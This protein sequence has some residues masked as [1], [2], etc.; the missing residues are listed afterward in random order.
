MFTGGGPDEQYLAFSI[1]DVALVTLPARDDPIFA[2]LEYKAKTRPRTIASKQGLSDQLG[3][4]QT[5]AMNCE[6]DDFWLKSLIP[7]QSHRS[8]LI[9]NIIC[10]YL[11]NGFIVYAFP[12]KIIRVVHVIAG[13]DITV[14]PTASSAE[15]GHCGDSSTLKQH[16]SLQRLTTS[17]IEEQGKPG[18]AAKHIIPLHG[19][20]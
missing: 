20:D 19:I 14:P 2:V 11:K 5:F 7:E 3:W 15:L 9:Y 10:C 12:T 16:L 18:P 1:D 4:F 6:T 13:E 8:Q 17:K